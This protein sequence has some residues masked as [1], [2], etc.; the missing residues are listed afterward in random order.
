MD[1]GS[2]KP[3]EF[4]G[5]AGSFF[6]I[7]IL[8]LILTYIPLIGWVIS[9][10]LMNNWVAKNGTINGRKVKYTA[11]FGQTFVF[12][13]VNLLLVIITLGIYLFWFIPKE[14]RFIADHIVYDDASAPAAAPVAPTLPSSPSSPAELSVPAPTDP[15]APQPPAS[16]V[17]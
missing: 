17:S 12:M 1:Q 6:V 8:T 14:Y 13:L 16:P 4:H 3:L 10:N 9:F 15:T 7:F 2:Q 5:K 11:T